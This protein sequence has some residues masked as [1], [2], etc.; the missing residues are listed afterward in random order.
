MEEKRTFELLTCPEVAKLLH[1]SESFAYRLV[2]KGQLPGVKI[3][4]SIRV[5]MADLS[6]YIE[7]NSQA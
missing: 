6:N 4:R 2:Q 5:K 3:G 1:I 7:K